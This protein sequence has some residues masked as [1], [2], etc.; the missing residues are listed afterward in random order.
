[1]NNKYDMH[2]SIATSIEKLKK[3][4]RF[5]EKNSEWTVVRTRYIN[6]YEKL[7][8]ELEIICDMHLEHLN[9][10]NKTSGGE[11]IVVANDDSG[12]KVLNSEDYF[13][14][15]WKE[16]PRKVGKE[17]ARK[18]F[19][20][21]KKMNDT[22]FNE[23]ITALQAQKQTTN[24]LKD[25]KQF[26]PHASTWLN[27]KRWEDEIDGVGNVGSKFDNTTEN[28]RKWAQGKNET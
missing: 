20:K 24:W 1:M 4:I 22:L 21:I 27:G 26:I 17:N 12:T 9:E 11:V 10:T 19:I 6:D 18:A 28:L 23:I 2:K 7:V 8:R 15:F 14:I 25:D 5:Y 13:N 3:D 16:Y